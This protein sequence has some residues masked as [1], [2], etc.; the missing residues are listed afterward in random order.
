MR[1]LI[2]FITAAAFAGAV[3]VVATSGAAYPSGSYQIYIFDGSDEQSI[4]AIASGERAAGARVAN[5]VG[6][7]LDDPKG[8]VAQLR[9]RAA[10]E[11]ETLGLVWIDGEG[12]KVQLGR[13][14]KKAAEREK[15]PHDSLVIVRDAG[16]RQ[17][18]SII[19]EI[20]GLAAEERDAMIDALLASDPA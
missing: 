19:R 6:R 10:H 3:L 16:S 15:D 14:E 9:E 2:A 8:T 1:A 11:D 7:L 12:S 4:Y 18:L 5:C 20:P 17:V 13:C